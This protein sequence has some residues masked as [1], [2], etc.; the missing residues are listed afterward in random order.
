MIIVIHE[1]IRMNSNIKT[2]IRIVGNTGFDIIKII[3]ELKLIRFKKAR[4]K[5]YKIIDY[6]FYSI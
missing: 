1:L 4:N 3:R 6:D 2:D 5:K